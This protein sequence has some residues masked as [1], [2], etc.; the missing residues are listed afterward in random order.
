M[1]QH[2]KWI[3]AA[4]MLL[5]F[6]GIGIS[7]TV[8]AKQISI[9]EI[10]HAFFHYQGSLE[11]Q[12]IRD[13]R[14]PR[15]LAGVFVGGFLASAGAMMQ[16]VLKNPVTEPS[17]MGITQGAVLAVAIASVSFGNTF[18]AAL[19][20]AS[21]SGV[22]IF[23]FTLQ[24]ASY[25]AVSNILLAGTSMGMFFISLAS[26]VALL[27]NRS[28]E[29]AFWVAGGLRNLQWSQ[30]GILIG[31]GSIFF[32]LCLF[33]THKMNIIAMGDEVASGL[34][35]SSSRT[36]LKAIVYIIPICAVCV[37]CVGNISFVGLFVPHVLR[38]CKCQDY[39]VLVPLSFIYGAVV[40]VFADILARSL[41]APYE[42]PVGVFTA[43]IGVPIFLW[44]VRK[45]NR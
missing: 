12:L 11:D 33:L 4:G 43:G 42:L 2:S 16:G 26:M 25:Q 15:I 13:V 40:L 27:N 24:K 20:G 30:V 28:S 10:V 37:A 6:T 34:G 21:L 7:L 18:I 14:L 41:M 35:V 39:R 5:L 32:I 19:L 17:I 9:Q 45:E 31:V 23:T 36:K 3:T 29:L 1:K 22:L 38:K 8:G 44:L